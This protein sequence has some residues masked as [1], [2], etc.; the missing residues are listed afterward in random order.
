MDTPV[1]TELWFRTILQRN[2]LRADDGTIAL[3]KRYVEA[4]LHA[5][6]VVNLISRKDEQH[7]WSHHILHCVSI[8]FKFRLPRNCRMLDLGSGG[9][10]PGIPLK[11]FHPS[12][13]LTMI[14]ATNKKVNIVKEIV[15]DLQLANASA[16]W[17]RAEDLGRQEAFRGGF[18]IVVARAVGP[19]EELVKLAHPFLHKNADD[20]TAGNETDERPTLRRPC[21][22]AYK[23]GEISRELEKARRIRYVRSVQTKPL[24]FVG[25]EQ[26][27]LEDKKVVIVEFT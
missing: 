13:K 18:D 9:G 10:L 27:T 4:L 1:S 17:G 23:G 12:L 21:L 5:N 8:L 11:I 19:L 6:E 16:V 15:A 26:V 25:S 7:I 20:E 14:D 2:G 22:V 3:V 24:V